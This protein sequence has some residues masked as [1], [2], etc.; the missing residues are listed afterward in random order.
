MSVV[1]LLALFLVRPGANRL[2]S[3]IINSIS[4][5]VGRPVDV[6]AVRIRLLPQPGFELENFVVHDD[7]AFSA[8]PMLRAQEVT[9]SLRVTSL[10]RGRLEIARLNLTE[11]SLN[12]VRD[13]EGHWNLEKLIERTEKIAV[14]P[15]SKAKTERRPGFPYIEGDRGRINFKFGAEKKPYA[16]TEADFALWQDSENGWGVRLEARP[17]RTDFNLSDTGTVSVNGSW[18]RAATLRDTPLQFGLQWERAQLG[19][20]TKLAYGNDKGWRGKLQASVMLTGTSANLAIVTAAS[21]QDFRRYDIL[22][23]GDLRLAGQCS[24]HYSSLDHVLS[25]VACSA[26]VGDGTMTVAGTV[27]GPF[28]SRDYDLTA[29]ARDLPIQSLIAFARHAKQGMPDDLIAVGRLNGNVKLRRRGNAPAWEG[30]GETSGFELRSKLNKTELVLGKVPFVVSSAIERKSRVTSREIGAPPETHLEVSPFNLALGRPTPLTVRGWASRSGYSFEAQGD[31]QMQRLLQV[32]RMAGIPT[33]QPAADG[34]AKVD[35]QIASNWSGFAAPRVMGK[36]QLHSIRAEVRGLN[37]P[38]EIT[39]ANLLLTSDQTSVQ[40]LTASIA[41]TSWHGSVVLPRNCIVPNSCPV[42]FDLHADEIATDRVNQLVNPRVRQQP[43]YRFLSPPAAGVPYL[44]TVHAAGKLTANRVVVHKL[45]ANRVSANVELNKGKL[46]LFDLR[47]DVLGGKHIGEWE[48]DFTAKPPEYSG[49]GTFERIALSQLSESMNDDWITGSATATYRAK[50]SGLDAAELFAS[51]SSTVKIEARDGLLR[52][53]A[54]GEGAAPL[55]M[56][57]LAA[58]LSLQDGKFEI[59]EG[60]LETAA[61]I[62]QVSGTA[63]LTRVLNLKLTHEGAA[64]F[65]ITGTLMEPHVSPILSP[66]TRA[67]LKP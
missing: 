60:K 29:T 7:P 45:I 22:G 21:V 28:S 43:W 52:H 62:Y 65:N 8:E 17:V 27:N 66:E 64:G 14:A 2:R 44:L 49:S 61:G 32:A 24:G 57:R 23:G 67:A 58:H 13:A 54:L 46:L 47:G 10:L 5:A 3:R 4:L 12:L 34:V 48:A 6:A 16:L 25:G 1:A 26:P 55:Q 39:S 40:N 38:L 36:A 15:T 53:I 31:A 42:R 59:Q 56:H 41:D 51:A 18:Q 19:Q 50:A 33:P 37:A 20:V 63:S 11:P 35:L 30:G 9:A